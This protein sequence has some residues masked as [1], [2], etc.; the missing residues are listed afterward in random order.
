MQQHAA[1]EVLATGHQPTAMP[2]NTDHLGL[3]PLQHTVRE[4][5]T[6]ARQLRPLVET[7]GRVMR[8]EHLGVE[9]QDLASEHAV[10]QRKATDLP[11]HRGSAI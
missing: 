11:Q 4:H 8:A 5:Q 1:F 6:L 9:R 7:Q 10:L 2:G 3:D